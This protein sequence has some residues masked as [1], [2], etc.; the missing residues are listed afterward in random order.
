MIINRWLDNRRSEVPV[1]NGRPCSDHQR[2]S[3]AQVFC[4]PVNATLAAHLTQNILPDSLLRNMSATTAIS[5][6]IQVLYS[7]FFFP[8]WFKIQFQ[9]KYR[10]SGIW[11]LVQFQQTMHCCGCSWKRGK[12]SLNFP[13]GSISQK[14]FKGFYPEEPI[15]NWNHGIVHEFAILDCSTGG[16]GNFSC[17]ALIL[18]LLKWNL[19]DAADLWVQDPI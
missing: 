9:S 13:K 15:G 14:A 18:N 8:K 6:Q 7:M 12:W 5:K 1:E 17:R 3:L 16:V 4:H 10:H 2:P 19:L 11:F